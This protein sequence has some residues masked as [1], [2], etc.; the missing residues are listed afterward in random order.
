MK[1][2]QKRAR[3]QQKKRVKTPRM[4]D[5][6]ARLRAEEYEARLYNEIRARHRRA[7]IREA[8][9]SILGLKS[10]INIGPR[11]GALEVMTY[12]PKEGDPLI[13]VSIHTPNGEEV[14]YAGKEEDSLREDDGGSES[15]A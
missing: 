15:L 9:V 1:K 5:R 10:G 2:K 6:S 12:A 11:P 8:E 3:P 4:L 7:V 13:E 14:I